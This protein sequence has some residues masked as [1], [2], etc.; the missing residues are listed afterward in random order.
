[1][2][3]KNKNKMEKILLLVDL[4]HGG[5]TKQM[6]EKMQKDVV[7]IGHSVVDIHNLKAIEAVSITIVGILSITAGTIYGMTMF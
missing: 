5:K 4:A 2:E 7:K 3:E 1:V 6:K